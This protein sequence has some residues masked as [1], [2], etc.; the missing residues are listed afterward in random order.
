MP[1]KEDKCNQIILNQHKSLKLVWSKNSKISTAA[2][3]LIKSIFT[4]DWIKRPC[5]QDIINSEWLNMSSEITCTYVYNLRS[6][7]KNTNRRME[8]SNTCY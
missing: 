8:D 7:F 1:F 4:F 2:K 3:N 5:I 6:R